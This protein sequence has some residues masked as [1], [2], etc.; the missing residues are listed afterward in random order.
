MDDTLI[1]KIL[2]H[3][4]DGNDV[5][6]GIDYL[7][8]ASIKVKYGPFKMRTI[9]Y[10]TDAPTAEAIKDQIFLLSAGGLD[11]APMVDHR[12]SANVPSE[13]PD[14]AYPPDSY[15][16]PMEGPS[17]TPDAWSDEEFQQASK[18][19]IPPL[20]K[21][22]LLDS[23]PIESFGFSEKDINTRWLSLV[24]GP[25]SPQ[26]IRIWGALSRSNSVTR[27][28]HQTD[29]SIRDCMIWICVFRKHLKIFE[30]NSSGTYKYHRP[31]RF[32]DLAHAVADE[33][34]RPD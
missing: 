11:P 12:G 17:G 18:P 26:A 22:N 3:Y 10:E 28:A 27:I 33:L 16:E 2:D 1:C 6:F 15:R 14:V 20:K 29:V 25:V 21:Q 19:N 31:P 32:S 30:D 9:V 23:N 24:D 8:N 5:R 7:G 34:Q 4:L 13:L